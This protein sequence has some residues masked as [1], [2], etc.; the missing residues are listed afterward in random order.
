MS[1][2]RQHGLF[3]RG[4]QPE[5]TLLAWRRTTLSAGVAGAVVVRVTAGDL[6]WPV[7]AIGSVAVLLSLVAYLAAGWRY[8]QVHDHLLRTDQHLGDGWPQV[9]LT[10]TTLLCGATA[11]AWVL[12]KH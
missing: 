3:D 10:C 9:Y 5:R 1:R 11:G 7:V 6:G 2:E 12:L 8:R 4:L